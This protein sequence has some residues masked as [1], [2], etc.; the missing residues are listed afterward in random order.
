MERAADGTVVVP[1][2]PWTMSMAA[3]V[4]VV[5]A[6]EVVVVDMG[7]IELVAV[8]DDVGDAVEVVDV[9]VVVV[10]VV[11]EE[12]VVAVVVVV[13]GGVEVVVV[14]V[15][16]GGPPPQSTRQSLSITPDADDV[17]RTPRTMDAAA[18]ATFRIMCPTSLYTGWA[19]PR[20]AWRSMKA[21][22]RNP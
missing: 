12:V 3:V 20:R 8:A 13:V 2:V 5:A 22:L 19:V 15:V 9:A 18:K 11:V 21:I 17:K 6:V 7:G 1:V 14:D 4:V 16:G 10:E